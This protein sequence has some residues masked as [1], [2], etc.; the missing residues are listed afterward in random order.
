MP[1]P[2]FLI[3]NLTFK[4]LCELAMLE[5]EPYLETLP[6]VLASAA[7]ALARHTLDE[8]PWTEELHKNTGY[9]LK[10][11]QKCIEFLHSMFTKAP[12]MKQQAIQEKYKREKYLH[13]ASL[14]PKSLDIQF[15]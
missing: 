9:E 15:D 7:I 10:H 3:S 8:T 14:T 13:V 5:T 11:L 2:K 12:K 1:T 6:S 4:Y